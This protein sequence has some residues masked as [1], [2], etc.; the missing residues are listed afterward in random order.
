MDNLFIHHAQKMTY[1]GKVCTIDIM[2]NLNMDLSNMKVSIH[3]YFT[4]ETKK[5]RTTIDL[6]KTQDVQCYCMDIAEK[7]GVEFKDLEGDL[8]NLCLSLERYR[9]KLYNELYNLEPVK[10]ISLTQSQKDRARK[11]LAKK[12]LVKRIDKLLG[13]SGIVGEEGNRLLMFLIALSYKTKQPL[14]AVLHSSSGSGKSHLIN[15]IGK[16]FPSEDVISLSR[17]TSKSLYHYTSDELVNKLVLVQDFDGLS[18]EALYGFRELQSHGELSSSLTYKD[19]LGNLNSKIT[20]VRGHFSSLGAT[21]KELYHDNISRSILLK[22][23]E[24]TEQTK[25]IIKYQ[26]ALLSGSRDYKMGMS[27]QLELANIV[28]S[29]DGKTVIN[30][31]ADK[32]WLP[33]EARMLRRL[34]SH[35]QHLIL[36]ITLLHQHQRECNENG[37]VVTSIEDL[38]IGIAL[39]FDAIWLKVDDLNGSCRLFFEKLKDY[40][41]G[42]EDR[43]N[44]TFTQAEVR[45]KFHL[46]K[47][48]V[49]R[50][51][52][53]LKDLGYINIPSGSKNKGYEYQVIFWDD[54]TKAKQSI[55][56]KLYK[57]IDKL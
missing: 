10:R 9:E 25:R 24:S 27:S 30:P 3:L 54:P 22:V 52:N 40:L 38:R 57:Q 17:V 49:Q 47:T 46:S 20:R 5:H 28:R 15:G 19:Q 35:F 50:H 53:T 56:D 1:T 7:S 39:F 48:H 21:T 29:L 44:H 33:V 43:K 4:D 55:K 13:D 36:M 23:D 11:F 34:N 51:L 41:E 45:R 2:G 18:G 14:H 16:C 12:D 8:L 37:E 42:T 32:L 26:N 6:Y 31:F